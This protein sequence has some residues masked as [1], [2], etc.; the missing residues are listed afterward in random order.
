MN[1][2]TSLFLVKN[3]AIRS[4][5]NFN[6]RTVREPERLEKALKDIAQTIHQPHFKT[7]LGEVFAPE[8]IQEALRFRGPKGEKA[9]LSFV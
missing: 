4:F 3:I 5:A 9:I 6:S 1:V 2:Q 7:K 8:E